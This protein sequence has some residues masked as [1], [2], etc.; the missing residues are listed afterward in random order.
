MAE[1]NKTVVMEQKDFDALTQK[2]GGEANQKINALF[3]E[4]EKGSKEA[5][6]ELK[7]K[8]DEVSMIDGKSIAEF[9]KAV[10]KHADNLEAELKKQTEIQAKGLT[11]EN[12]LKKGIE[13]FG[14]D[15][16]Q[17]SVKDGVRIPLELKAV[18]DHSITDSVGAGV[19]P[20]QF[21][22]GITGI[23]KRTPTLYDLLNKVPWSKSTVNWVEVTSQEISNIAAKKEAAASLSTGYDTAAKFG[24]VSYIVEKKS[25]DLSKI[26]AYAKVTE[27]MVENIDDFVQFIK[28][29]MVRDIFLKLDYDILTGNGTAPNMKGLE[30]ADFYTAA[31]IP[32]N[33]ELPSG[34]IPTNTHILRAII[35]QM[36]NLYMQANAILM[37]PTDIMEMDLAV[38]KNGQFL[39]PPFASRDNTSVKGVNIVPYAGIT[40]GYFHVLDTTRIPLY[41]Q[42]GM[43]LKLWDQVEAD[44]L[45]D[46]MTMTAS[47]KAGIRVK[48]AEKGCNIYGRFSTLIASMTAGGS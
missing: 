38:D 40:Q 28:S 20:L 4:A 11:F 48:T 39:I 9:V 15:K 2:L 36:Q 35:T 5:F 6:T 17:K 3:A 27:E 32:G 8:L 24:Q 30:H 18:I 26:P 42:R 33:F 16:I 44:P 45:Y 31:A 37:H 43:N 23:M 22:Q 14:F 12:M 13:T 34:I 29:E 10:Q 7:K 47:I 41:I 46:L 19:I 21:E 1:E 25:M